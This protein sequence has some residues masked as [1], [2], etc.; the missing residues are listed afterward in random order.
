MIKFIDLFSGIGGFHL[1]LHNIGAECVFASEIDTHARKTYEH[2]FK[3]I[4]STITT[5]FNKD[6]LSLDIKTIPDFDLLCAGFPCQPFSQAGHK[7]GFDEVK[8][9]RG[10]MFYKI[11]EILEQKR[12]KAFFLENVSNII[13]HDNGN[14]FKII[15]ESIENIDYTFFYKIV[16][17]S[18]YGLPQH[19]ARCFM[20]GFDKSLNINDFIFPPSIPLK[21]T[22]SDVF[23]GKCDKDIGYTLRV[24]GRGSKYGDKHNWE[25]YKVDNEIKRLGIKE[26]KMLMGFPESF[27]FP[28]SETQSMKQLG[29]SVAVD[30]IEIVAKEIIKIIDKK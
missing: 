3:D 8:A 7:K 20:I 27:H 24:G 5:N 10:N 1:A 16:K 15:Q 19:R 14:T 25:F 18:D 4:F 2:N 30:A 28:V 29:N 17:A 11:I 12:P 6:I 23:N 9:N 26:G 21:Y 22:I 13:K